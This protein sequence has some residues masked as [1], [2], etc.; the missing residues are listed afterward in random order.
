MS[1]SAQVQPGQV[2]DW[3]WDDSGIDIPATVMVAGVPLCG[4]CSK[5]NNKPRTITAARR[6][7]I[8]DAKKEKRYPDASRLKPSPGPVPARTHIPAASVLDPLIVSKADYFEKYGLPGKKRLLRRNLDLW[9]KVKLLPVGSFMILP[10][11]E[12]EST[13][14]ARSRY[15][16]IFSRLRK[17]F[18]PDFTVKLACNHQ[19]SHVV[20]EKE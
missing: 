9:A 16:G 5:G 13:S 1:A 6:E 10:A 17:A 2:C 15:C 12:G 4:N 14:A 8:G 19:H 11:K 20:L 7:A 18:S 3:C